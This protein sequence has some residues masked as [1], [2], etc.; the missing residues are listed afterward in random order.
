MLCNLNI[1]CL[2]F[3]LDTCEQNS[4]FTCD[5]K[6]VIRQTLLYKCMRLIY[7]NNDGLLFKYFIHPN[8][9]IKEIVKRSKVFLL[10]QV[11]A[12]FLEYL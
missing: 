12:I 2:A 7:T 11:D 8:P 6:C 9:L 3:V 1:E 5:I 10:T 4:C